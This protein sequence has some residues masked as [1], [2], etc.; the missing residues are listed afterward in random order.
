MKI[1]SCSEAVKRI[2]ELIEEGLKPSKKKEL[3]EHLEVCRECCDRYEFE[4]LL[5]DKIQELEKQ[6]K[7]PKRLVK[8]IDKLVKNF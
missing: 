1:I 2:F 4:K 7:A 6:N 3:D 5:K 8:R